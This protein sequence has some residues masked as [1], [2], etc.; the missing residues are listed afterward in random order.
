MRVEVDTD[1]RT[2]RRVALLVM[3]LR[4][5][6]T[7]LGT[8]LDAI[9]TIIERMKRYIVLAQPLPADDLRQLAALLAAMTSRAPTHTPLSESIRGELRELLGSVS[10]SRLRSRLAH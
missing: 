3:R 5:D 7:G 6:S 10:P 2:L 9:A 4:E 8:E 1:A